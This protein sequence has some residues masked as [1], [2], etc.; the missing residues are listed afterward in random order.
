MHLSRRLEIATGDSS[1]TIPG[2]S[3][4]FNP[5]ADEEADVLAVACWNGTV[6]VHS[7]D[8]AGGKQV[9]CGNSPAAFD[10]KRTS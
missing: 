8:I 4:S 6:C 9:C 1:E 10:S 5:S 2:R 7:M 3:V